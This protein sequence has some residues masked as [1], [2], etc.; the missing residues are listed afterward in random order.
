MTV[1]DETNGKPEKILPHVVCEPSQGVERAFLVFMFDSYEY[2]KERENVV[3]HLHPKIAP[4]KA[5]IF[6]IVKREDLEKVALNIFDDLKNE[7]QVNLDVSGSI[8]RRYSRNDEIGTP[9]CITID[10]ESLKNKDVTI[11]DRDTKKQIRVKIAE[12][13]EVMR[14]LI[15]EGYNILEFGKIY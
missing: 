7:W 5:A 9:Y 14:K 12:L 13:K 8:G 15:N 2:D 4:I 6:P 1:L 10:E 11:R 3:L